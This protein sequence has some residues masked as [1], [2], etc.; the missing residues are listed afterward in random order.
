MQDFF[1]FFFWHR[2]YRKKSQHF[3]VFLSVLGRGV[4]LVTFTVKNA[5]SLI[6]PW[7]HSAKI[8]DSTS[9][10]TKE[11]VIMWISQ[12]MEPMNI[13]KYT[14]HGLYSLQHFRLVIFFSCRL[15]TFSLCNF[16]WVQPWRRE[17]AHFWTWVRPSLFLDL[18]TF[19]IRDFDFCQNHFTKISCI[20][21]G[22]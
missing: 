10:E 9:A 6:S 11:K 7:L 3:W 12:T 13:S 4:R 22:H 19:K 21:L 1:F 8:E 20:K 16:Y 2:S 18:N 15:C 5:L 14:F 17:K